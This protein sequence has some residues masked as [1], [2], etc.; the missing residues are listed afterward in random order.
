MT[1]KL[2]CKK[3]DLILNE[4]R[5]NGS[6]NIMK[7]CR[8]NIKHK[9]TEKEK[10]AL[11][12]PVYY[13]YKYELLEREYEELIAIL[14]NDKYAK[15]QQGNKHHLLI[16]DSGITFKGYL[17]NRKNQILTITGKYI[18]WI[19]I[20]AGGLSAAVFYAIQIFNICN[21]N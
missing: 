4:L 1:K 16:T 10:N 8:E 14:V 21:C 17:R 2:A 9:E 15:R 11:M 19:S 7:F 13:K 20:V 5:K 12:N 6:G 18:L 3:L